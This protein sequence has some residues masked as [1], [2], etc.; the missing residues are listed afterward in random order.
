MMSLFWNTAIVI[1]K[2]YFIPFLSK[3]LPTPGKY[4]HPNIVRL[5]DIC[6][7]ERHQGDREM[8]LYLV[9]EHMDQVAWNIKRDVG[10]T[11]CLLSVVARLVGVYQDEKGIR[12][13]KIIPC[14]RTLPCTWSDVLYLVWLLTGSKTSCGSFFVASTFSTGTYI[15]FQIN[16]EIDPFSSFSL[17]IATGLYIGTSSPKTCFLVET[18]PSSWPTLGLPGST[19][20]TPCWPPLWVNKFLK[21]IWD[22]TNSNIDWSITCHICNGIPASNVLVVFGTYYNR[23]QVILITLTVNSVSPWCK[24]QWF[25]GFL[26][27]GSRWISLD[28]SSEIA[29]PPG[30]PPPPISLFKIKRT[31]AF[32]LLIIQ[33]P[34]VEDSESINLIRG[35]LT[36][37][38]VLY[39]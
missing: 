5:V 11:V 30:R 16:I 39:L 34:K 17:C 10:V 24:H 1:P 25:G 27:S 36:V 20:L 3:A 32:L 21:Q 4:S 31:L 29:S 12:I 14:P 6:H 18:V 2:F 22:F 37:E 19:T 13:K 15:H 23:L 7:G 9:F 26:S 38:N 35:S 8:V 28:A 33:H